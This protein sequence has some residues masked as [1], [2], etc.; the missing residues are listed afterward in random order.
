MKFASLLMIGILSIAS[1]QS[2]ATEPTSKTSPAIC[3]TASSQASKFLHLAQGRAPNCC[4]NCPAA[5]GR[6]GCP[7]YIR[8][9]N[10]GTDY[11]C[12]PC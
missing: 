1:S 4:G 6:P 10:G 8:N 12:S 3:Q 7:M 11:Y 5:N 2:F 9:S